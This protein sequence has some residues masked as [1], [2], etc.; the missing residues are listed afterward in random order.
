MD[1]IEIKLEKPN[2]DSAV[3]QA[4]RQTKIRFLDTT[5]YSGYRLKLEHVYSEYY[6]PLDQVFYNYKFVIEYY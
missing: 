4:D 3:D 5:E 6:Y 1:S 2:L